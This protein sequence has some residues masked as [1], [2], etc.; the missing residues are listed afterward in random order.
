MAGEPSEP[1]VSAILANYNGRRFLSAC[2][3]SIQRQQFKNF[4]TIFVDDES[5]D[6]SAEFVRKEFPDVKVVLNTRSERGFAACCDMGAKSASSDYLLFLNVDVELEPDC[7]SN[8]V[9]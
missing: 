9:N 6:G 5:P 4:E 3:N 8:L 7:L 2:F 1:M